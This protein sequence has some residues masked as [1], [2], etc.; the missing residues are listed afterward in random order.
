[1]VALRQ[2]K[3]ALQYS[4]GRSK[5]WAGSSLVNAFAE[6][7]DGD[8]Y[9]DFAV[10]AVPGLDRF[11]T[12]STGPVR[13]SHKMGDLLYIVSGQKLFSVS[14][15]GIIAALGDVPGGDPVRM[16][17]NGSELAIANGGVP[18]VLSEGV[19]SPPNDL[20]NAT[21]VVFIDG[22]FLW[23]LAGHSQVAYSA[24]NQG[25]LYDGLDIISAEGLPGVIEG[26]VA[27][28]REL[29]VFKKN[30]IEIFYNSG[31]ADNAFERQ[32]NAFIERGCLDRNSAVKIDNSIQFVG[33]DRIV[34]R[35]DGYTPVRISS[36]A[37]E[38]QIASATFARAF[39]YTQEGHKFYCLTVDAGT[40]CY[41]M[42]TGAW[43]ERRSDQRGNYRIGCAE[44]IWGKTIMA[45]NADGR[46]YSPNLDSQ[47]EDGEQIRIVIRLPSL[48]A[49]RARVTMYSFE[50]YFESGVGLNDGQG[51]DP[52]IMMRYSDDGGR[53]WSNEMWRPLGK[54]GEYRNRSVWRS[55]G[56]FRQRDIELTITDPVR[57]FAMGYYADAR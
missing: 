27:S 20:L 53:L 38:Y 8:K 37:I 18:L 57:K 48:E 43:H 49:S 50:A 4:E 28:H 23:S 35:L 14:E 21:D 2:I 17:D 26:L 10:M 44:V 13:G 30:S 54:I 15:A 36:H 25:T 55:L 40:F 34:Y 46:L 19:L 12:V 41:D 24:I 39:T 7:G 11:V 42:A 47:T 32:G 45:D 6:K 1:M 5:P 56:Q 51:S 16:A 33:D 31:G 9:T 3:P 29:Y 22:Y 52:Q